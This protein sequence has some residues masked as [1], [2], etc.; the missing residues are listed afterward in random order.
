MAAA[1]PQA[2]D[3]QA[4]VDVLQTQVAELSQVKVE[5]TSRMAVKLFG[6][7]HTSVFAKA[8]TPTGWTSRTS[9]IPCRRMGTAVR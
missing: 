4:S 8:A 3:P 5:S 1:P 9:S 2:A 6:T 7:I